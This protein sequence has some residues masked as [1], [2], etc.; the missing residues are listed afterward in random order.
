MS[1]DYED[2]CRANQGGYR[3]IEADRSA[4]AT[5]GERKVFAVR[6]SRRK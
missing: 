2:G 6:S 5:R 4:I 1:E 3:K